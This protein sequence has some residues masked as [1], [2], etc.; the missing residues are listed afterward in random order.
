VPVPPAA[1]AGEDAIGDEDMLGPA[2]WAWLEGLLASP[3]VAD[4]T[5]IASGL[6]VLSAG[7]PLISESWARL[8]QSLAR[9]LALLAKH[10]V[11]RAVFLSGDV[12]FG[13]FN[14]IP[15]CGALG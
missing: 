10:A 1:A 7:D 3:D 6:Q 5:L 12:H 13:E 11:S 2:Q 15:E 8:P 4:V 14:V 9:L